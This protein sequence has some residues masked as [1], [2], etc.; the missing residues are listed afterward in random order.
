M[1]PVYK[2]RM[3]VFVGLLALMSGVAIGR[4]VTEKFIN[5]NG[6]YSTDK[7]IISDAEKMG[8]QDDIPFS[9]DEANKIAESLNAGSF[10]YSAQSGFVNTSIGFGGRSYAVRINATNYMFKDFYS[11]YFASGCFF[12]REAEHACKRVAVID[13][14][15]SWKLFKSNNA[16]GKTVEMLGGTFIVAGVFRKDDSLLSLLADD[17]L[18][19]V[20]IPM[21][22]IRELDKTTCIKS[23]QVK[24]PDKEKVTE[25]MVK[26][27]IYRT[28]KNPG[29]YN[30]T[31]LRDIQA[32]I[33]QRPIFIEFLAGA[34]SI[35]ILLLYCVGALKKL[36]HEFW[37]GC[38]EEYIGN[39]I[40]KNGIRI[41]ISAAGILGSLAGAALIWKGIKFNIYIPSEYIPDE[42]IDIVYYTDLIKR[43]I[44]NGI[45]YRGYISP[46]I[47]LLINKTLLLSAV[48][49]LISAAAGILLLYYG[50]LY[51][52]IRK[53]ELSKVVLSV[54]CA[55]ILA[56]G[57]LIAVA[58]CAKMPYTVD[59]KGLLVLWA[60]L[61]IVTCRFYIKN[62]DSI[63]I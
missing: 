58:I 19:E 47:E 25:S 62:K 18:P 35:L 26:T 39:M 3:L 43:N 30:I 15:L 59:I 56:F 11:F 13:D 9:L 50:S 22:V 27:A 32:L 61:H 23:I 4:S 38:K 1:K 40:K 8:R 14:E 6:L 42:L 33:G 45:T 31:D 63:I 36:F 17:G 29:D 20:Y 51:F 57:T 54:S 52:K 46:G 49:F 12:S 24:I 21:S 34:V 2:A 37:H 53:A 60:S 44:Q 7:I 55:F 41:G 16:I 5:L 28:G 48:L 10:T